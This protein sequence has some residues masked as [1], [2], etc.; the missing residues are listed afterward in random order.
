MAAEFAIPRSSCA[1]LCCAVL[2]G[3]TSEEQ[4]PRFARETSMRQG[5]R[6]QS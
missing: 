4:I 1:V 6:W 5:V 3:V 2:I